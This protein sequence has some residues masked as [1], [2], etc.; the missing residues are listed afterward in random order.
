MW[1]AIRSVMKKL[2]LE[3]WRLERVEEMSVRYAEEILITVQ[4]P[5]FA[6]AT[7]R[8]I[9]FTDRPVCDISAI[10][11]ERSIRWQDAFESE[12]VILLDSIDGTS[13]LLV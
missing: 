11:E 4:D 9:V 12:D 7:S 6:L 5:T 8:W 3:L 1:S 2:G 13:V 10:T